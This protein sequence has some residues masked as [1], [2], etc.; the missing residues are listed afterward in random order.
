MFYLLEDNRI[1]EIDNAEFNVYGLLRV[2]EETGFHI[3]LKLDGTAVKYT[4]YFVKKQSENVYDLIEVGDLVKF[5]RYIGGARTERTIISQVCNNFDGSTFTFG[6]F[7]FHCDILAI[8]KP[9]EKG[10]YIKV[11]EVKEDE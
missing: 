6:D 5:Y 8:Y 10:N 7:T 9:D 1:I 3:L 11:W 2:Y 4:D